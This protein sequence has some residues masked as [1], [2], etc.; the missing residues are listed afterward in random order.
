MVDLKRL[1]SVPFSD[2]STLSP[3]TVILTTDESLS[4]PIS[5]NCCITWNVKMRNYHLLAVAFPW[6]HQLYN[7]LQILR[8]EMDKD[9][10]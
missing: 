5:I 1:I 6:G 2:I 7:N 8:R 4:V 10:Y 3:D 9:E